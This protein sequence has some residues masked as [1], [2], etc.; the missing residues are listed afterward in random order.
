MNICKAQEYATKGG[1]NSHPVPTSISIERVP[2]TVTVSGPAGSAQA[3]VFPAVQP[4]G[5]SSRLTRQGLG[6]W[7]CGDCASLLF[8]F[9]NFL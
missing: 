8:N 2:V 9:L 7:N 6:E 1:R 5:R 4:A 3:R